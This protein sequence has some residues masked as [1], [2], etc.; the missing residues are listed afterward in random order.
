MKKNK[1]IIFTLIAI[2]VFV[3]CISFSTVSAEVNKK[4]GTQETA[5]TIDTSES[6]DNNS[7]LGLLA[8]CIITI[9]RLVEGVVTAMVRLLSSNNN[10]TFPW[11]DLIIFNTIPILDV[12]FINPASGSLLDLNGS[13][14][15]V[16]RNIYFTGM[17][18][19]VGFLSIIVGVMAVRTALSTIAS[20][21]ARY[22]ETIVTLI[23][24]LLL[25]FGMHF[26]LSFLFYMNESLVVVASDIVKDLTTNN[27]IKLDDSGEQLKG[28]VVSNL[29]EW[30]FND[31]T[32]EHRNGGV[33]QSLKNLTSTKPIP[34]VL[35]AMFVV[36]SIMFLFAYFKR[37]FYVIIL[38]VLAPFVV[39]YDFLGKSLS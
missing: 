5:P 36:Q 18:I 21:K 1:K 11:A 7:L 2:C 22:K 10:A 19:A 31:A 4:Y 3:F 9:A 39:I 12:N 14:G 37:F 23:T 6:S 28:T 26:L 33:L 27:N 20:T 32:S 17:S 16:I 8:T 15:P 25:L 35:Y 13:I 29:G 30:F 24:T 34:A 38:S